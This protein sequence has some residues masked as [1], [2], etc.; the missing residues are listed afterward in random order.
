M[1]LPPLEKPD[2]PSTAKQIFG[3]KLS[4]RQWRRDQ[5]ASIPAA[6]LPVG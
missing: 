5:S 2:D 3:R 4:P 1:S 6:V